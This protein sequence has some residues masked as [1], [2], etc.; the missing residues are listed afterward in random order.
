MLIDI[1]QNIKEQIRNKEKE[2]L[3]YITNKGYNIEALHLN[4][5]SEVSYIIA[6]KEGKKH[7][8][9]VESYPLPIEND[10]KLI[11]EL[12]DEYINNLDETI[13][14]LKEIGYKPGL[15]V[16]NKDKEIITVLLNNDI[17]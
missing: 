12:T 16:E 7:I 11:Y 3:S 6:E 14:Y 1:V 4:S 8:I 13:K 5:Y 2:D 15:L 10:Y 9:P 17:V